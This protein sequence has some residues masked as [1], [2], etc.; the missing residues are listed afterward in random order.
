MTAEP[1]VTVAICTFSEERWDHLVAAVRSLEAQERPADQILVVVDHNPDLLKRAIEAFPRVEVVE[2]SGTGRGVAGTR[3]T[4]IEQ[5]RCDIV[6]Y[7]DDDAAARPSWL[8]QLLTAYDDERV[9]GTGCTILPSWESERPYWFPCE[10]DWVIGCSYRGQPEVTAPVRNVYANGMSFLRRCLEETGA[11]RADLGR[12]NSIPL[13]GEE[14]EFCI[15]LRR[16]FPGSELLHVAP[17]EVTHHVPDARLN[18]AYFLRRCYAEGL[19]KA[20]VTRYVGPDEALSSERTY[21]R[22]TLPR[23]V[24]AYTRAALAGEPRELARA[25]AIVAGL[26]VTVVGYLRGIMRER[27]P[28]PAAEESGPAGERRSA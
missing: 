13:G 27:R 22:K 9:I 2:S 14:T 24:L 23:G 5:S 19:S 18:V 3:N 26:A 4:A 7:L 15:R 12:V 17:A 20:S 28:R 11:F 16:A 1:T 8:R 25:A 10:F 21:T 6:A